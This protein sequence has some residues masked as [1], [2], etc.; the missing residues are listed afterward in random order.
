MI[1][2]KS[3]VG[4]LFLKF[5][6]EENQNEL[7]KC[8]VSVHREK[9]FNLQK[10]IQPLENLTYERQKLVNKERKKAKTANKKVCDRTVE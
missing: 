7:V 5:T 10:V 3:L 2:V 6:T 4:D 1:N 8:G 9:E